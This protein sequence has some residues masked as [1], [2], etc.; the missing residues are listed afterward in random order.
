M[1]LK[2]LITHLKKIFSINRLIENEFSKQKKE[3]DGKV[4]GK[5]ENVFV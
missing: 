1:L 5:F 4:A 2:G 3:K